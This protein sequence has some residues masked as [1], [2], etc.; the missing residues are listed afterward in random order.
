[1]E[2]LPML[3][4]VFLLLGVVCSHREI[5]NPHEFN[6]LY[7]PGYSICGEN[8]P[9]TTTKKTSK[10][11]SS[12]IDL[13][14]NDQNI[15]ILIYVHTSVSNFKNRVVIR[16]TFA[17]RSMFPNIRLVFMTGYVNDSKLN[18]RLKL[19]ANIYKDIVQ[20]DFIDTYRNI[21][22]KCVM[23]LK[24][25]STFCT[26]VHLSYHILYLFNLFE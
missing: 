2:V 11:N 17:R 23:A 14:E 22:H 13:V 20:E 24:W 5:I 18:S 6:Y 12:S 10:T 3:V 15:D 1:M 9:S 7:N 16:E 4:L 26:Q 25:I 8:L 21:T 19:E